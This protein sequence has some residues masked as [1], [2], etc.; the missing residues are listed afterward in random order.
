[1]VTLHRQLVMLVNKVV[2]LPIAGGLRASQVKVKSMNI[3]KSVK[4]EVLVPIHP[5]GWPFIFLFWL[6]TLVG[7]YY[8]QPLFVAGQLSQRLV[9]L[10]FP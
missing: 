6:V 10:F 7:G 1:M 5:A 2:G 4:E 9:Y 3:L 8:W